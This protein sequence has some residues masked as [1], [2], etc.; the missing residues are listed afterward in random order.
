MTVPTFLRLDAVETVLVQLFGFTQPVE[1]YV[2]LKSTMGLQSVMYSEE[3]LTLNPAN[4][5]QAAA[6]VQVSATIYH[7]VSVIYV[8]TFV[9]GSAT[10]QPPDDIMN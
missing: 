7:S 4:N 6:Q 5:Y 8:L 3:R 9:L 2:I 10:S 1:V